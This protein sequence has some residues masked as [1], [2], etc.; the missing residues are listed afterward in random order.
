MVQL[1]NLVSLPHCSFASTGRDGETAISIL[2][3]FHGRDPC[4]DVFGGI[5]SVLRG[6]WII[7]QLV[8]LATW[9]LKVGIDH[10]SEK[11]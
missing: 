11:V 6:C 3:S 10:R 8:S 1:K 9:L 7:F 5:L 2:I 4:C